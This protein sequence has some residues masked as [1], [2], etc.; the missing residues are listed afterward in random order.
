MTINTMPRKTIAAY[1]DHGVVER[2]I[3]EGLP[4]ARRIMNDLERIGVRFDLVAAQLEHEAVQKFIDPYDSLLKQLAA[5]ENRAVVSQDVDGLQ[6]AGRRLRRLVIRMTTEAG[7]GHPTSCLSCADIVAALFFREKRWD[8]KDPWARNVDTFI[9]SKGHAAPIWWAALY[10]A[11][12]IT[13]DPLSLRRI[14]STLEGHPTPLNPW[15]RVATGSLGQ[16]LAAANGIAVANR[17]DG[18]DARVFCLLGDGG[19]LRRLSVGGCAVCFRQ[20]ARERGCDRRR[21][22]SRPKRT[23]ALPPR[24]GRVCPPVRQLRL[25]YPRDRRSRHGGD[26]VSLPGCA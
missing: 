8:P 3:D 25:A 10:E 4:C 11:G 22:R 21:Q 17:L 2:T 7:S 5:R 18:I 15:V 24:H 19:M 1:R 9:L 20:R 14:D 16:G 13:E 6:A 26:P 12:A 23:D